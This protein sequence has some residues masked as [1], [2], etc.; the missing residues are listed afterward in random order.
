MRERYVMMVTCMFI[1]GICL[2]FIGALN[3]FIEFMNGTGGVLI[4]GI[5]MCVSSVILSIVI[6]KKYKGK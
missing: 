5:I 6:N 4:S 2:L 1:S 3:C